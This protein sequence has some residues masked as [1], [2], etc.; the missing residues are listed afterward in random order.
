MNKNMEKEI[1][2]DVLNTDGI[3]VS[4][5]NVSP[6]VFDSFISEDL[7][8][9]YLRV[10]TTNQRSGNAHTKTRGEVAGTGKKP[11]KQKGTG[12]A[13]V[14]SRRSPIWVGGGIS[15]GPRS[16]DFR[17]EMPKKMRRLSLLSSLSSK[18]IEGNITVID[19]L[20]VLEGKSKS[21]SSLI[22]KL[23]LSGSILFVTPSHNIKMING[24]RNLEKASIRMV[25]NLNTYD[26]V[27]SSNILIDVSGIKALEEKYENK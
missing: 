19:D 4:S 25:S 2:L 20:N 18:I 9:Q 6:N 15:H 22:N 8:A 14:G 24:V 10:Y 5:I 23:N 11:W 26:I 27:S 1:K 17:L 12:R 21:F 13:R 3:V 16:K 7:V